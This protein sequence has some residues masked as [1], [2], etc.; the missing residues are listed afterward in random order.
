M[1]LTSHESE[2]RKH[3]AKDMEVCPSIDFSNLTFSMIIEPCLIKIKHKDLLYCVVSIFCC[4]VNHQYVNYKIYMRRMG[5][6]G[7][8][9][10]MKVY[11]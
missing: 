7:K 3:A 6:C 9:I 1:K 8:R 10:R 11:I 2:G 4:K 5:L